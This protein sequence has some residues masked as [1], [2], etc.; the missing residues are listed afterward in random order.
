[1]CSLLEL[2]KQSQDFIGAIICANKAKSKLTS[3]SIAKAISDRLIIPTIPVEDIEDFYKVSCLNTA[4][5]AVNDINNIISIDYV[6][7][8]TYIYKFYQ[9]RYSILV[10]KPNRVSL[11]SDRVVVDFFNIGF[12]LAPDDI[13]VLEASPVEATV[14]VNQWRL[15]LE[16][17]AAISSR[18]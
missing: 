9:L 13:A 4:R 16:E 10:P 11:Q 5:G 6:T 8:L 15:V 7:I 12:C 17:Q 18:G 3:I 14:T 2:S 1:M